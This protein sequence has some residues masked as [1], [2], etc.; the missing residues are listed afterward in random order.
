MPER[1]SWLVTRKD[2]SSCGISST[3]KPSSSAFARVK[4]FATSADRQ[5]FQSEQRNKKK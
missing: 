5:R 1:K 3:K 2:G 4:S